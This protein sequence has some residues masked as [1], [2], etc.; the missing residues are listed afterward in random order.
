MRAGRSRRTGFS[1]VQVTFDNLN[2]IFHAQPDVNL[3][4]VDK[5]SRCG[6]YFGSLATLDVFQNPL[7]NFGRAQTLHELVDVQPQTRCQGYEYRFRVGTPRP[8]VLMFEDGVVHLP[9]F[10]LVA[11]SFDGL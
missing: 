1:F 4:T 8:I 6:L 10:A 9:E 7:L 3:F 5:E 11:G 2:E